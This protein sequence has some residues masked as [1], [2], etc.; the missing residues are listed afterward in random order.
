SSTTDQYSL[1]DKA[2]LRGPPSETFNSRGTEQGGP[3]SFSAW[4]GRA[5]FPETFLPPF[6]LE[7]VGFVFPAA[8][9]GTLLYYSKTSMMLVGRRRFG[10]FFLPF[11]LAGLRRGGRFV[12]EPFPGEPRFVVGVTV[13]NELVRPQVGQAV[14]LVQVPAG[15]QPDRQRHGV[16]RAG[17]DRQSE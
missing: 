5:D 4:F 10:R 14:G 7:L 16:R 9:I 11:L 17:V 6:L 15:D 2:K 1:N 13:L 8:G 12:G 3:V